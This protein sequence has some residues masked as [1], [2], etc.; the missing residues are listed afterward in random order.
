MSRAL[1]AVQCLVARRYPIWF[2][3]FRKDFL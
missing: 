1:V 2:W 3:Y